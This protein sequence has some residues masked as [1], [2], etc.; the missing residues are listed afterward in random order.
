MPFPTTGVPNLS[1]LTPGASDFFIE[2]KLLGLVAAV[3]LT[4]VL[5]QDASMYLKENKWTI[6]TEKMDD[7]AIAWARYTDDLEKDGWGKFSVFT[8]RDAED[9]DKMYAAGY[10]EGYLTQK[11]IWEV[12]ELFFSLHHACL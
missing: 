4:L 6:S 7:S 1:A 2:M 3:G 5:A 12:R 10:L 8:N 11:R 9:A